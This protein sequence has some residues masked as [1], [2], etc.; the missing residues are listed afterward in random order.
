MSQVKAY[1]SD[2][3]Y[4]VDKVLLVC[5]FLPFCCAA[6]FTGQSV[7]DSFAS[8]CTQER[9]RMVKDNWPNQIS[10]KEAEVVA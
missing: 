8:F 10:A 6:R 4:K 2:E 3:S 9:E 1:V 5:I 7:T